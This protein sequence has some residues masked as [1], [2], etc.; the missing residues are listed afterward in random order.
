MITDKLTNILNRMAPV[1]TFQVRSNYAPWVSEQTKERIRLRNDAQK[2]ASESKCPDDWIE[3]RKIRNQVNSSVRKEKKLWQENKIQS[4]DRDSSSI[5]KNVKNWLGWS[6]GGPPT[7]LLVEG[8]IFTKPKDLAK[9]MNEFFIQKVENIRRNLP[10]PLGNPLDS[11]RNL[12]W[13]RT[14]TFDF[15]PVHPDEVS[16]LIDNL[17]ATKSCGL[18]DI[19]S[20]IIKLTKDD[21]LAPITHVINL[22]IVNQKFPF[23]W[24][25]A[26]VIPLHKK[27]ELLYPQNYRPVSLLPILSKLLERAVFGQMIK[28]LEDNNLL[29][30][31]HHGFRSRHNT[32]TALI[33]M[34]DKWV[35]EFEDDKISAVVMLDLSAAFDVVDHD[36]LIAKLKIYGFEDRALSWLSSYLSERSQMVYVDGTLSEPLEVRTGVPQGSVL[37]P[38]LYILF[39][40]DLPESV[41]NHLPTD[42]IFY[43]INCDEC[44][45]ICCFA[46]DS[47]LTVSHHNVVVLEEKIAEKYQCVAEFMANNRLKLNSD[48]TH[49][50]IMTS[51]YKHKRHK[52]FGIKL[53]TGHELIEPVKN[54]KLLGA[55]IANN[56]KW[57]NHIRDNEKS[58]FK[59][60][61]S[62]INALAK[63]SYIASFKTRKMIANG[64]VISLV[65]HLIQ[66]Y[67]GCSDY[68]INFIQVLQNKAAILVTKLNWG[69]ATKVLLNQCGWL[70]VRQLVGY[71]SL[72][73]MFK[74][75]QDRKP[76][77]LHERVSAG[78][79]HKTRQ[80]TGGAIRETK[81]F[82]EDAGISSFIPRTTK[83]WNELPVDIRTEGNLKIFKKMAR[84]WVKNNIAI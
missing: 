84:I 55:H 72:V 44:G 63:I 20:Y 17:K 68:L 75:L 80:A 59:F 31:S 37:G 64:I 32:A 61:T 41:H 15:G 29:H 14:C 12:M 18:D 69:T 52:N 82:T 65:L 35:E 39:T 3:F 76:V 78:Y 11:V 1:K 48:K 58:L 71:H 38:L 27:D 7:K 77:Y 53:D 50:I 66:L 5:W 6:S 19:D 79:I 10:N 73:L 23:D 74:I 54:E 13:N 67:G 51:E 8:T 81:T 30:P 24:K 40:N 26:K 70:S 9:I 42:D 47:T 22:S 43:N 28:Y 36:I 16:K 49:M 33:Q 83:L 4:F 34:F 21:L 57:N 2:R 25:V 56:F 45:H 46:D 60:L 62:R